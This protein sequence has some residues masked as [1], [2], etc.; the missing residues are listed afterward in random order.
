V[1]RKI[2][3]TGLPLSLYRV[4][5]VKIYFHVLTM[6]MAQI[7]LAQSSS[8]LMGARA[9]GLGY[10]SAAI[11][12]DWS[13]FN[14]V[15]GL[16]RV[17]E[18]SA[19]FAYEVRPAL[20]G[21]NRMA[22]SFAA[23]SKMGNFGV[24][25]FRF[26]DDVY[27]EHV[28]SIGIGNEIGNTS[29]GARINYLQ[30]RAENF[31]T[32]TAVS[33]DLAGITRLTSQLSIGAYITNL[34][35]STLIGINDQRLPTRLVIGLAFRPTE[36]IFAGTEIEK[37]IDYQVTWRSGMEFSI[38]KKV[39][40]RTGFNLN[41]NATYFGLGAKKKNLKIDYAIRFNQLTGASHQAS[42]IYLIS[43]KGHK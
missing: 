30:S 3:L 37:D 39:F 5:K 20:T 33:V 11:Q 34:T 23:P 6:A 2:Y 18:V 19:S 32:A 12:D 29:L 1:K 36:K 31:G 8:T 35:Q 26:G 9:A 40:F 38:Y 13:L 10:T 27:S 17:D 22:A 7:A 21:A 16:A 15:A 25:I 4:M 24:G 42:A 14:N 43:S 28:A 41:P